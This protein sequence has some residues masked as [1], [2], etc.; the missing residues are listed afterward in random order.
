MF[1][2]P[3][4]VSFHYHLFPL[5]S[6]LPPPSPFHHTFVCLWGFFIFIFAKSLHLFHPACLPPPL[7]QLSVCFLSLWISPLNLKLSPFI[8]L[9]PFFYFKIFN[10]MCNYMFIFHYTGLWA[11]LGRERTVSFLLDSISTKLNTSP[12]HTRCLVNI[13]GVIGELSAAWKPYRCFQIMMK[14]S[15]GTRAQMIGNTFWCEKCARPKR[16][17]GIGVTDKDLEVMDLR[18]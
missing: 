12:A 3:S 2:T 9:P 1:T 10:I 8:K 15:W 4:P 18:E 17:V 14:H 11:S 5:H 13:C 7:W 16:T 6:L